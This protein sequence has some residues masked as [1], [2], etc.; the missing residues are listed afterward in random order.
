MSID[1]LRLAA[2]LACAVGILEGPRAL[3][4]PN[5]CV[6]NAIGVPTREGPPKWTD[7]FH[8]DTAGKPSYPDLDDPRWQGSSSE[9]FANGS[10]RAP[11]QSRALWSHEGDDPSTPG[12]DEGNDYL[13]LS[14]TTNINPNTT[15]AR[16]L[17]LGFRRGTASAGQR[18]YIFQFHLPGA[19]LPSARVTPTFCGDTAT[20]GTTP[21]WRVWVDRG[22]TTT[23]D[24]DNSVIGNFPQFDPLNGADVTTPPFDWINTAGNEDVVY[25]NTGDLW[26]VQ[27]RLKVAKNA[28]DAITAGMDPTAKVW[29]EASASLPG[30]AEQPAF[31]SIASWPRPTPHTIC[32]FLNTPAD[33][34]AEYVI[35]RDLGDDANWGLMSRIGG[36]QPAPAQACDL[37]LELAA[38]GSMPDPSITNFAGA[39]PGNQFKAYQSDGHTPARNVL[40]AV[41]HNASAAPVTNVPLRAHFR[42]AGW[43]SAPWSV[44]T[45]TGVWKP[46]P[47]TANG[48]CASGSGTCAGVDFQANGAAGN[49]DRQA[50]TF[51]WFIGADPAIG[52][53][54][55]CKYGLTPSGGSCD[56]T[57][58]CSAGGALC[59]KTT[60]AGTR[61]TGVA[62]PNPCVSKKYQFDQCML[63][64]LDA[65][66]GN[67]TFTRQSMWN[68]MTFGQM[69]IDRREAL[70][71]ARQLPP[72]PGGVQ[73]IY[74]VVMPRNM[75]RSLP[76]SATGM[77]IIQRAALSRAGAIAAPY[78]EDIRKLGGN[79]AIEIAAKLGRGNQWGGQSYGGNQYGGYG[80]WPI[81]GRMDPDMAPKA[82]DIAWA[83]AIM[84][85]DAYRQ[86]GNLLDL[87]AAVPKGELPAAALTQ[88]TVLAVG[89]STAATIVPTLEIYPFYRSPTSTPE[90]PT[91]LPMT[92]FTV[93]LSHEGPISGITYE[94]DGARKVAE[95]V[96]RVRIPDGLARRIQVRSQALT[97]GEAPQMA[98]DPRW[99]CGCCGGAK[100]GTLA[101][102]SNTLPGT[103]AGIWLFGF[104]RRRKKRR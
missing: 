26:A 11:L 12:V 39:N 17:W 104:K 59:D 68:N 60:D 57:C 9:S 96:Y 90:R 99:P 73:D 29:F 93:F 47:G 46:I 78:V 61:A 63:V 72:A 91:Y 36:G 71:D 64:E 44:A 48:I 79:A 19:S 58:S 20:C 100:C 95:N 6:P 42:L 52:A 35:H 83:R 34:H 22:N 98:G 31:T 94:I 65:P 28:T 24:C 40:V 2:A 14:F 45:D 56:N 41:T 70:I 86:V 103:V 8:G 53:S 33:Q 23:Y 74:L 50:V 25:W 16:D 32:T 15:T 13:Y 77:N 81:E 66:N 102:V 3:A 97:A 51:N 76:S 85:D 55:F 88:D 67:A 7:H 27:V 1:K 37:G 4:A 43:G 84:P 101:S 5:S 18:S 80:D 21:N 69:S 49:L 87:A 89:P 92:S 54:E 30:M 62:G 10:A 75:P 38:V 82:R